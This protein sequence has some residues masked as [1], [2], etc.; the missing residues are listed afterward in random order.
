MINFKLDLKFN[1]IIDE[2]HEELIN[3]IDIRTEKL[4]CLVHTDDTQKARLN[5]IRELFIVALKD[6]K[7]LNFNFISK[8][9]NEIHNRIWH[10]HKSSKSEELI[11][12]NVYGIAN[13]FF[14]Y[15][16]DGFKNDLELKSDQNNFSNIGMD[17]VITDFYIDQNDFR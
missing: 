14:C 7:E 16:V 5:L 4:L 6:Y 12:E 11:N 8:N 15:L 2:Y 3:K 17:L 9:S 1:L 13:E 10:V